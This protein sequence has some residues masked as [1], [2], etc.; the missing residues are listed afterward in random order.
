MYGFKSQK[1]RLEFPQLAFVGNYSK[2]G[3]SLGNERERQVERER[4][5]GSE[6]ESAV[7]W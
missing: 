6:E 1:R 7:Q 5:R 4:E 3:K 2:L